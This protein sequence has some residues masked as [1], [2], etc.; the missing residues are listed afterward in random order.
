MTRIHSSMRPLA[1][2]IKICRP[3]SAP[4]APAQIPTMIRYHRQQRIYR[5]RTVLHVIYYFERNSRGH[6]AYMIIEN[7]G[8]SDRVV[9]RRVKDVTMAGPKL[10]HH[11][12]AAKM[13]ATT[14]LRTGQRRSNELSYTS[15][16]HLG[17]GSTLWKNPSLDGRYV[18]HAHLHSHLGRPITME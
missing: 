15:D 13:M 16:R 18:S 2:I 9:T 8:R 5:S 12:V 4:D 11:H 10:R 14:Q 7:D 1:P 6:I 3:E 17:K